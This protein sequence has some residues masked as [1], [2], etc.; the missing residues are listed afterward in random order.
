M[1]IPQNAIDMKGRLRSKF[2]CVAS[3]DQSDVLDHPSSFVVYKGFFL[4]LFSLNH[5]NTKLLSH[6][7]AGEA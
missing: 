3:H 6:F 2:K 1:L 5:L 4:Y 7:Q